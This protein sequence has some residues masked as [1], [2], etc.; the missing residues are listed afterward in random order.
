MNKKELKQEIKNL[1]TLH[2]SIMKKMDQ[3][4]EIFG[5]N[6]VE[7]VVWKSFDVTV[8]YLEKLAGDKHNIISFYIFDCERGKSPSSMWIEDNQ[9]EVKDIESVIKLIKRFK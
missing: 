2:K 1:V 9:Y 3:V 5:E 7:E 6:S 8:G 4:Y